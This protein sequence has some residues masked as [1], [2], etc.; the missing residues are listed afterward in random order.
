MGY[1]LQK[2]FTEYVKQ[3]DEP[4]EEIDLYDENRKYIRTIYRGETVNPN[5]WK[6]CILCFVIDVEGNVI[7][8]IRDD[9]KKDGCSG[10]IKHNEVATQAVVREL[11]E[12]YGIPIKES[13]QVKTF[14]QYKSWFGRKQTRFAVLFR[15]IL[16]I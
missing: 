8:E 10:H 12:E 14:R 7:V 11:Y 9:N 1:V 15:R 5:E 16:L 3:K 13:I 6:E 2:S 4:M